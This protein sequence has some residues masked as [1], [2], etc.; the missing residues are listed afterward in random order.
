MAD[1]RPLPAAGPLLVINGVSPRLTVL[2]G[3]PGRETLVRENAATGHAA[4]VLAPMVADILTAAGLAPA[5]LA[6]IACVRG[7][8]SFTGIRVA[9]ATALGLSLAT[10]AP[11]AGLEYLPLLA[12]SAARHATGAV[13]AVTHARNGQ[14]YLQP[15]LADGDLVP[16]GPPEALFL[17]AAA[18]RVAEG[19]AVG[20]LTLVGDG[21]TRH[22][23]AL[24]R[25]APL[26][27]IPGDGDQP[28]PDTVLK[29]ARQAAYGPGQV[30]PLYLRPSDA[31]ENLA[32]LAAGRGLSPETARTM[33]KDA[34]TRE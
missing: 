17:D 6:G 12:A 7:P 2:L 9:L 4:A 1:A 11:M 21:A 3:R 31:E 20:P 18:A 27:A 30:E 23:A 26:A 32:T 22:R 5:D 29:L 25:A 14:V 13:I 28:D 33:L 15:F 10:G 34:V 16:M 19:A 24:L 8:G